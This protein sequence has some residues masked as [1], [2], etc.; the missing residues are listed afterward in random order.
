VSLNCLL[1]SEQI[2]AIIMWL[3]ARS[4]ITNELCPYDHLFVSAQCHYLDRARCFLYI[5]TAL[6][7]DTM[8]YDL[9]ASFTWLLIF[10]PPGFRT[11]YF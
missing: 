8:V 5:I 7:L 11:V 10:I 9:L 6:L 3:V 2:N 4:R 1:L